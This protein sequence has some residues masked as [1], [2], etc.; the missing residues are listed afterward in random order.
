M[1]DQIVRPSATLDASTVEDF[2]SKLLCCSPRSDVII[3]FTDVRFCD[4][5]AVRAI[6]RAYRRHRR[7]GG[8]VRLRNV[9]PR[10]RRVFEITDLVDALFEDAEPAA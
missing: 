2:E 10:V 4:S 1:P 7:N 5:M 8:S 9:E 3:D 6:I